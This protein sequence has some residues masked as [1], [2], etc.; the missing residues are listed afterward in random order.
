MP[1]DFGTFFAVS[2][3]SALQAYATPDDTLPVEDVEANYSYESSQQPGNV[4]SAS[5]ELNRTFDMTGN[6]GKWV[7]NTSIGTLCPQDGMPFRRT[8]PFGLW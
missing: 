3:G 7:E 6:I 4:G 2:D 8:L 5:E 1:E